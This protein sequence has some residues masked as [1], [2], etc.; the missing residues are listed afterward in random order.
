MKARILGTLTLLLAL[1]ALPG[2][3]VDA[4]TAPTDT[5]PGQGWYLAVVN[6]GP[7]GDYGIEPKRQRLVLVAPDG[8]QRTLLAR[9]AGGYRNVR[10]VDWSPDGDTALLL[11]GR[12]GDSTAITV[13]VATGHTTRTSLPRNAASVVLAPDGGGLLVAAFGDSSGE[14]MYRLAWDGTRSRLEA[15]MNAAALPSADGGTLLTNGTGWHQKVVR[16]LSATDGSVVRRI[17]VDGHCQ[18]VS[19]WDDHRALLTCDD[20]LALLDPATGDLTRL[21]S[22]HDRRIG[23]YGHLDARRIASGLYVEVAGACGYQFL[24]RKGHDGRVTKVRVPHALGNV[25]LLGAAADRLVIE[26]ARSCDG[27]APRSVIARFDP[28]SGRERALVRLP[29]SEDFGS[30]LAYGERQPL[31]Y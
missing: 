15:R 1:V 23:D 26:H 6:H 31:G 17:H 25:L 11:T 7:R 14:P 29:R 21:T 10:L 13:D 12:E 27:S 22:R 20:D 28:V 19:W 5:P 18:P 4:A 30:I 16:V 9:R 3:P 2:R 24:G 8:D